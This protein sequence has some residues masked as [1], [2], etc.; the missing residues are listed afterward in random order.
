MPKFLV[1]VLPASLLGGVGIPPKPPCGVGVWVSGSVYTLFRHAVVRR[2]THL[3]FISYFFLFYF[4]YLFLLYIYIWSVGGQFSIIP[5]CTYVNFS[6][7]WGG[8]SENRKYRQTPCLQARVPVETVF[9][10]FV[11]VRLVFAHNRKMSLKFSW[12]V[13][14]SE[15]NSETGFGQLSEFP[16]PK[17]FPILI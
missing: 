7:G 6:R 11:L 4:I 2:H 15:H 1:L 13:F 9:F 14:F 3:R 10:F 12:G 16:R 5:T 17:I 8:C